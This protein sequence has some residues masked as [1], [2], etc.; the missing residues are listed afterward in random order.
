MDTASRPA[1]TFSDRA[2][3][4][5]P[6]ASGAAAQRARELAA[7]GLS[8][9]NM[10]AGEP[11]FDTPANIREAAVAA[12][13]RGETRYTTV[14]GTPVLK[15]AIIEKFRRENGL[16]YDESEITV[17]TGAKQVIFNAIM[18]T[19]NAGD[20]AIIPVP[21]WV[22]YPE[23]IR[24]AGGNPVL[25]PGDAS[26]D[27]KITPA[28]LEAA[29]TPKTKWLMLNF[30]NNPSGAIL[31]REELVGLGEV[32]LRHPHVLILCDDI[33]EHLI[34]DSHKYFT[35][36]QAVP[37]LKDRVLT[38]NGVSKA[39]AMTGWRIGYAG[40]PAELIKQ[41]RK[42]QSQST[43][44]P[45]SI[46]QA[47]SVAALT[48]PQDFIAVQA[49]E[50]QA[51]RDTIVEGLNRIPGVDC[52]NPQGAF[53]VY[54]SCAAFIGKAT[55]EGKRIGNDAD[56]VAYLLEN[57]VAAVAGSAYGLSPFFRLSFSTTR[58]NL[59]ECCRRIRV[60]TEKLI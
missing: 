14:D 58:D 6:S 5:A 29:I 54:P 56:F 3:R 38:V 10:T 47:A 24:F 40:G 28:Q 27:F 21:S 25:V 57:G 8:I 45:C 31:S 15:A 41:M 9:M 43:S 49:A 13:A 4:V 19:V 50:F 53:Y 20:E 35:L 17:S 26:Q 22:S 44:N 52:A 51:R 36:A 18:A 11:D 1:L 7:S 39:Y 12:M 60:A 42:I 37:A 2:L 46:S 48:G 32:L 33:Y 59:V 23:M 30:P 34:Y 16:E 55:P